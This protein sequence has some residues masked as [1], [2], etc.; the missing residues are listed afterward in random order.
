MDLPLDWLFTGPDWMQY[1]LRLDLCRQTPEDPQVIAARETLLANPQVQELVAGLQD[2]PGEVLNS[3]KSAKQPFHRLNFLADIGLRAGDPGMDT[4][5][6]QIL[7]HQSVQGPFQLVSNISPTYGGTGQD[8]WAWALCDAPLLVYA[9]MQFGLGS[10]PQVQAA[11]DHLLSLVR[12][13]GWPCAVSPEMGSWRGPGRKDDPCPYANLAMLKAMGLDEDLRT[14]HAANIGVETQLRLWENSQ[15]EHPYIFYMGTDFRKLK[16][17]L[18]WYDILHVLDV[19]S[20][21]PAWHGDPRLQY[22]LHVL[23]EKAAPDGLFTPESVY[24]YW[25]GW[26]FGQKKT[27]SHWL[28]FLAWR[29]LDRMPADAP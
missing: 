19:L 6:D 17:P 21:F 18:I 26:D 28:T 2:W 29:I 23:R 11:L 25:K 24:T 7:S 1:R 12:E 5:I 27:P 9:L 8:T 13:N 22:M 10:H 15:I 14:S 3:H 4:I 20:L 16:A